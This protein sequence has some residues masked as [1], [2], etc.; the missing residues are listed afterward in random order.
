MRHSNYF[1]LQPE[2]KWTTTANTL[3]ESC[4]KK[5]IKSFKNRNNCTERHVMNKKKHSETC[6]LKWMSPFLQS[7]RENAPFL[8]AGQLH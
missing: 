6:R 2:F 7:R 1:C 8:S 3:T 5:P 4:T